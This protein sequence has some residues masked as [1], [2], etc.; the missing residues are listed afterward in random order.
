MWAAESLENWQWLY[1]FTLLLDDEYRYR[2]NHTQSHQSIR[3]IEQLEQPPLPSLGLTERPQAMPACYQVPNQPVA[4][5]RAYYLG[6]KS[7]LM[8]Y[9]KRQ[10]PAWLV[11][12]LNP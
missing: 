10:P 4:A 2:F 9:T 8:R 12:G 5:Y 6:E 1:T 7:H 3:T 11:A